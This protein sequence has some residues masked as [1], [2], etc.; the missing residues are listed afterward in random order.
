MN[1]HSL[2]EGS[3]S[4]DQSKKFVPFDP[5]VDQAKDRPASLFISIQ[6]FVVQ[7]PAELILFDT[8]LGY[9]Q[10]DGELVVHANLRKAGYEPGDV[11]QVLMSHLHFD[12]AGGMVHEQ[13]G[14]WGL[15]FPNAEYVI[16]RGEWETAYS[17]RSSSYK[18]EIFDIVQRSGNLRF[19]EGSGQLTAEI[20]YELTG[21]HCEYH[22]VF[23]VKSG[24]EKI[25]FGGDILPEP[26]Q[27]LRK[28][29]A[30]YDFDGR[31]AMELREEY[32]KRA[33]AENWTCLFYH[34]K[35]DSIGTVSYDGGA[36]RITP[37]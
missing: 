7:T 33:A 27:L 2:T 4:V 29:I 23:L 30:K 14:K 5:A 8:G 10:A 9:K 16:Q 17:R 15:S 19:I 35:R 1:I 31:K 26:E 32:G 37:R 21:G 20:S 25:F 34:S 12:H 13:D 11:T 36:F 24:N 6:P 18:T 22:Q 3:F 28:F